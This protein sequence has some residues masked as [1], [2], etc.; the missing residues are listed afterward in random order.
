MRNCNAIG[1][2]L[3]RF[4]F[5]HF[6]MAKCFVEL[7]NSN[8]FSFSRVNKLS[9]RP[10]TSPNISQTSP[11]SCNRSAFHLFSLR[12]L[13]HKMLYIKNKI[14]RC[15]VLFLYDNRYIVTQKFQFEY[16]AFRLFWSNINQRCVNLSKSW[17]VLYVNLNQIVLTIPEPCSTLVD[18]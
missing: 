5:H 14:Y 2:W 10:V 1:F 15:R 3:I 4:F 8:W 7:C 12:S 17:E 9:R 11:K 18:I 13:H 16:S 6:N